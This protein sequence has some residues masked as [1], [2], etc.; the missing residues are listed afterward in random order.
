M[1]A[2]TLAESGVFS[3][4]GFTPPNADGASWL[5][6]SRHHP[7]S[8]GCRRSL[9]GPGS[10]SCAWIT[11]GSGRLPDCP[12]EP[13]Y[14]AA[15]L[16][17]HGS[18]DDL[19]YCVFVAAL[20]PIAAAAMALDASWAVTVAQNGTVRLLAGYPGQSLPPL[21]W[22]IDVGRPVAVA[23]SGNP[24]RVLWAAE[25]M[26][27]LYELSGDDEPS[28]S[29]LPMPAPIRALALSP[30]GDLA[31]VAFSDGTLRI[32]NV[33]TEEL[34]PTLAAE[35]VPVRAV[36][37]ASDQGPAAAI[38]DD[39]RILYY[40]LTKGSSRVVGIAPHARLVAVTPYGDV[41]ITEGPR[42]SVRRWSWP[43]SAPPDTFQIAEVI[44]AIAT[45]RRGGR[46]LAGASTGA[47]WLDNLA[48]GSRIPLINMK[49]SPLRDY[50][51]SRSIADQ[52][53]RSRFVVDHDVRFT[54]YRPL[55][56]LP[57]VWTSLLVFAH[58]TTLL[59]NPGKAPIDP[60]VLVAA[61]AH[62]HFGDATPYP[63]SADARQGL[64]RGAHLRITLDLPGIQCNPPEAKIG[65]WEPVHDVTF[66]LLAGR[67]LAGTVV[68]GAV[69]IWCGPLLLG[70]VLLAISIAVGGAVAES[71]LVTDSAYRY[72]KIFPSYSHKDGALVAAF[73]EAARVLGD[74]YL[75]DLLTLRAGERWE[76]R[77]LQLI[78]DAD[79]FQ[80][81]W[82]SNS[83]YSRHCRDEWEHALA[84]RRPAFIR[85]LY[86]EEPLPQDP[87]LGLPPAALR[88]SHFV[89]VGLRKFVIPPVTEQSPTI[90]DGFR[91]PGAGF[92]SAPKG[93]VAVE[94]SDPEPNVSTNLRY[95]RTVRSG[96]R[97]SGAR[98]SGARSG[99][100][101]RFARRQALVLAAAALVLLLL[102]VVGLIASQI[103]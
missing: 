93:S 70:E 98:S 18:D 25:E 89:K 13:S 78:E 56:L 60:N 50:S 17:W 92:L 69:R 67:D 103:H 19:P 100:P 88:E 4:I 39:G 62:A 42:G 58:K 22:H 31:V 102:A 99:K 71:Q 51:L 16:A 97:R 30:S 54:V 21:G 87:R 91:E 27:K 1:I 29:V 33:R 36:A 28:G 63:V 66:R 46:I 55:V 40:D 3:S 7:R 84:L 73:A 43:H 2:G 48:D 81:F 59:E 6:A 12:Q 85:P 96:A 9:W 95:P 11:S 86:W 101:L 90:R 64:T 65:W 53:S 32:L 38:L 68:R 8:A 82:S 79:V 35:A 37:I 34:G 61:R 44:T 72:R 23:V 10:D 76:T 20:V 80:L 75:Q 15:A 94:S 77:L 5:V 14:T 41:V 45:D 57:E 26:L 74:R 83:M 24:L 49:A 52:S 47:V